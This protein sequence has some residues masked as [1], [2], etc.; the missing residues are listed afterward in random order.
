MN[1]EICGAPPLFKKGD[2]VFLNAV[3]MG[4]AGDAGDAGDATVIGQSRK[5]GCVRIVFD[6]R[7]TPNI[8]HQT[9]LSRRSK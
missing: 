2:R 4:H 3:W 9:F 8:Y 1:C 5:P 7:K 6:G